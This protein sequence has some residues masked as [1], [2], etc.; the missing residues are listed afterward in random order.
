MQTPSL[1]NKICIFLEL[2]CSHCFYPSFLV[3]GA[4]KH[5]YVIHLEASCVSIT[6]IFRKGGNYL[7][8]NQS[9]M[10]LKTNNLALP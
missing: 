10:F 9:F 5:L 3:K 7:S 6:C 2:A 4:P 1:K 8:G